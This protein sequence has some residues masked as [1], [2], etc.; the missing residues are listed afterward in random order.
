MSSFRRTVS[1]LRNQHI[2]H[3]ADLIVFV[4]GGRIQYNKDQIYEGYFNE[5]TEDIIYWRYVFQE[6]VAQRSIKYKSVG[7]KTTIKEIAIDIIENDIQSIF[8]AMDN[9]F[10][11]VLENRISH[12]NV[13]YTHGYSY[14]N[15][16]WNAGVIKDVIEELLAIEVDEDEICSNFEKFL[17]DVKLGVFADGYSFSKNNSFFPRQ[18][19]YMFCVDC[20]PADLPSVRKEKLNIKLQQQSF[21]LSTFY[22]FGREKNI[23]PKKHCFGHLLADY[24]FQLITSF[25]KN[26]YQIKNIPKRIVSRIG[27]NKFFQNHFNHS[28]IYNFHRIQIEPEF[29]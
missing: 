15:D 18:G 13:L 21:S 14:E 20:N 17:K 4:E 16:I 8:V 12:P 24:S 7:S 11:E 5:N 2:F 1:G 25:I 10:D 28:E 29:S 6:F 9:E 26:R 19:G 3:R 23:D 27:L 22:R